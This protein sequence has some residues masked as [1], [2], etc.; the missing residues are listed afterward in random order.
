MVW[1][2][3]ALAIAALA[4]PATVLAPSALK[5]A[6]P[7]AIEARYSPAYGRCLESPGGQSTYGMIECTAAELK[8]QDRRLNQAY[9]VAMADLN[10]RQKARLKTAQRAWIAFRDADCAAQFDEDWGSLARI[11]ANV[12]VL[13]RTVERTL[14]LEAYRQFE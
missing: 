8:L 11:S 4:L 7:E 2:R 5:A 10:D 12:C 6:S 13:Q 3:V 14:E 9:R 1:P